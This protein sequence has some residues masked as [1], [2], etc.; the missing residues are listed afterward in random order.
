[1]RAFLLI[2]LLSTAAAP[3][4]V[5]LAAQVPDAPKTDA[6]SGTSPVVRRLRDEQRAYIGRNVR[7]HLTDGTT[8]RGR[9]LGEADAGITIQPSPSDEP[10]LIPY[11]QVE[12]IAAGMQRW[13]KI[14]IA[15]GVAAGVAVAIAAN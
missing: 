1:M 14:A 11:E 3:S 13:K 5:E 6:P 4:P 7:V 9:L 10:E 12:S 2:V 8:K 15:A